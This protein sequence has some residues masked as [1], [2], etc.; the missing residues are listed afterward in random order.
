MFSSAWHLNLLSQQTNCRYAQ[1]M[2]DVLSLSHA[3]YFWGKGREDVRMTRRS[4]ASASDIHCEVSSSKIRVCMILLARVVTEASRFMAFLQSQ[5]TG[6]YRT[7]TQGQ[8]L[9]YEMSFLQQFLTLL[10]DS[11]AMLSVQSMSRSDSQENAKHQPLRFSWQLERITHLQSSL[12]P[13]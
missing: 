5:G 13:R 8:L 3:V 9:S 11:N 6:R 12:Q 2:L 1:A 4:C 10:S 7:H